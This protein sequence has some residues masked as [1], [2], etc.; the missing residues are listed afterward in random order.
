MSCR[1]RAGGLV[2][3]TGARELRSLAFPASP[4]AG[5]AA[6]SPAVAAGLSP[7]RSLSRCVCRAALRGARGPL[8]HCSPSLFLVV[9]SPLS[10]GL[11]G[12]NTITTSFLCRE[13]A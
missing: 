6:T 9:F 1:R 2:R 13:C 10:S 7:P 11:S 5:R 12:S 4:D 3:V 8:W